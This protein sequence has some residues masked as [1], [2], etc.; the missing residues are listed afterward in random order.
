MAA[1]V[2]FLHALVILGLIVL[3]PFLF[4]RRWRKLTIF[5]AVY[6][7]IFIVVNRISQWTLGECIF[8]RIARWV[9]GAWDGQLFIVKFSN[10]IFGFI[11]SN[12]QVV[13]LEQAMV[14]I[15]CIGIL[16]SFGKGKKK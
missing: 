8:T 1:I 11:P 15:V 4:Y 5:A 9:G 10:T 16:F 14:L 3:V 2:E 12:K 13:L 6:S 7:I